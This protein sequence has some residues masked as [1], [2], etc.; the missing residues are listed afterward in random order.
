MLLS[1]IIRAHLGLAPDKILETDD[2]AKSISNLLTTVAKVQE[3]AIHLLSVSFDQVNPDLQ[4][5]KSYPNQIKSNQMKEKIIQI[6]SNLEAWI[7][8]DI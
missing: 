2:N 3:V 4:T 1:E 7:Y 6:E 8:L 5:N